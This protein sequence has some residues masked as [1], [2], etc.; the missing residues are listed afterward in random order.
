MTA[1]ECSVCALLPPDRTERI[2]YPAP[3]ALDEWVAADRIRGALIGAAIGDGLGN[4]SHRHAPFPTALRPATLATDGATQLT[5]FT[6]DG[7]LR[8]LLRLRAKGIGPAWGVIRHALDRWVLVRGDAPVHVFQPPDPDTWPDGWLVRQ[9]SLHVRH[10][11]FSATV[12]ALK[13]SA[14]PIGEMAERR[15]PATRVNSSNGAGALVRAA[16]AGLIFG[17]EDALL[18]GAITAAY[19]HGGPAGYLAPAALARVLAG[20]VRGDA[21]DRS[22]AETRE[23]LAQWPE[24]DVVHAALDG[25]SDLSKAQAR[26]VT[27]LRV[28]LNAAR[29]GEAS[30]IDGAR[31]AVT[32]AGTSAGVVAGALL[33]AARGA[34]A[35][36]ADWRVAPDVIDVVEEIADALGVAHRAWVMDRELPGW[37]YETPDPFEEHP[38]CRLLWP[39]F[40]GW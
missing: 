6:A 12:A 21:L 24:S 13:G 32:E 28:G 11:G 7:L 1:S 37:D 18:I 23:E 15:T 22:I 19:T 10:E 9:H 4:L 34:A 5:M 33:G 31:T 38:V 2:A 35:I 20:L 17:S 16:P 8:M 29:P 40:P 39:R 30:V 36:E 25:V 27:A 3:I 14:D 26:A